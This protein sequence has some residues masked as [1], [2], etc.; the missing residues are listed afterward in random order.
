M[1]A[2]HSAVLQFTP[3]KDMDLVFGLLAPSVEF[4]QIYESGLSQRV[5]GQPQIQV[6]GPVGNYPGTVTVGGETADVPQWQ[7]GSFVANFPSSGV[8]GPDVVVS[9][10]D[11]PSNVARLTEWQGG[12]FTYTDTWTGQ[13]SDSGN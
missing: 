13:G 8:S 6:F 2:G 3:N 11:H 5:L 9:V 1:Y 7:N 12:S 10:R 4:V